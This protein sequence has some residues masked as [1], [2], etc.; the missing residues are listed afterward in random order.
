MSLGAVEES[1]L[2]IGNF[3][4]Y[5][6]VVDCLLGTG[7]SGT[8]SGNIQTAI[9]Q[10]NTSNAYII[11]ADINSGL[12]GDTGIGEIAVNS[13][14]TVSIGAYKT[15]LFLND[16]PYYIGSMINTDIGI[17]LL[18]HE[19]KLIDFDL[20]H[21]FEGYGSEIMTIEQFF[22]KTGYSPNT[23]NIADCIAEISHNEKKT[24][25][26]KTDHSAVIADLKYVYFC[27]DYIR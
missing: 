20:L 11:S 18:K 19:Y 1:L 12:N 13:D 7:F 8:V 26:V 6:I 3:T 5:D 15:G 10:I 9:E 2:S 25:V 23:C 24:V 4:G 27:A 16:A 17:D 21:M 14:L 22:E